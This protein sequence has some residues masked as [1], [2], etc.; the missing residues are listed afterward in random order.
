M[1]RNTDVLAFLERLRSWNESLAVEKGRAGFYG[2]DIYNMSDSID[3]VLRYLDD[4]DAKSAAVAR[5]R[6]G[7]LT[8]WQRDP[9]TYSR[10][11]LSENYRKC[12]EVVAQ[13]RDLLSRRLAYSAKGRR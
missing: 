11:V 9:A 1:W 5:E 7:C 13:C 12:E 6:Y 8:P 2:L 10:A 3:A 4:V